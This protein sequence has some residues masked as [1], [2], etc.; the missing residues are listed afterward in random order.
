MTTDSTSAATATDERPPS[1]AA[2]IWRVTIRVL[3]AALIGVGLGAAAYY[4]VPALYRQY[5]EPVRANTERLAEL[6]QSIIQSQSAARQQSEAAAARM[7]EIEA[8]LAA[9]TETLAEL[10]ADAD[11]LRSASTQQDRRLGSLEALS[12]RVDTLEASLTAT[13]GELDSLQGEDAPV[14]RLGRQLQMIRAME[15]LIR[16]RLWLSQSNLGLAEDDMQTAQEILNGL[17]ATSPADE[18]VA[19]AAISTRL[20]QAL[21]NLSR[22][23]VVA[24]D[25][26]EIAWELLLAATEP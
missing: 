11:A 26:L 7:T 25:D 3:L 9:Q 22:A 1:L 6:E 15:L 5:V 2:R 21:A 19:L 16:A 10:R 17:A 4:G 18:V 24:A 13:A 14:Q 12:S 8:T 20:D 23:P